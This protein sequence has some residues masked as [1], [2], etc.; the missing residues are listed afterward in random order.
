MKSI[1]SVVITALLAGFGLLTIFLTTSIILDLFDIRSREGNYVPLVVWA[2]LISGLLFLTTAFGFI[3]KKRWSATPLIFSLV[4]LVIAF[5]GLLIHINSGGAYETKTIGA[6]IFRIALNIVFAIAVFTMTK[7]NRHAVLARKSMLLL[8]PLAF[9]AAAC[10]QHNDKA[11]DHDGVNP[12]EA[13]HHEVAGA[14][15]ALNNGEKWRSDEHTWTVAQQMKT[16]L[17]DFETKE[18]KDYKALGDSLQKK[19]NVLIAG[20]TMKGPDHDALHTWLVPFTEQVKELSKTTNEEE[21]EKLTDALDETLQQ[22]ER[23]FKLE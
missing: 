9:I 8:L 20:C 7:T 6:M 23:S 12:E 19:L 10:G 18:H 21:G 2:N 17:A 4:V 15:L 3:K 11:H 14:E 1:L 5:G 16:E 13:H 22:F